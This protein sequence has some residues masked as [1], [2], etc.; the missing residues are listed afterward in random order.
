MRLVDLNEIGQD[1]SHLRIVVADQKQR[2]LSG[3]GFGLAKTYNELRV[4]Q[5]IDVIGH[6]N[7]NEYNG[8]STIQLIVEK[9]V[10]ESQG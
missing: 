7:K 3:I 10:D 5:Y 9:I 8:A 2:R 1:R 6:L 4:G